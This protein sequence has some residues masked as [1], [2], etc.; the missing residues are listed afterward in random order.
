MAMRM[1]VLWLLA[2]SIST[3][4]VAEEL[5]AEQSLDAA[6]II[7]KNVAARGGLE[8]WRK[9]QTMVW[10][11][12]I[13]RVNAGASGMP[14]VL[15]QKRPNK[16]RFEIKAQDRMSMRI[17]DGNRGWKLRPVNNGMP[18]FQPFTADELRFARDGQGIEG[19]LMDYQA[20]GIVATL[21]GTDEVEGHKAYRLNIKL[22]S[23]ASHHVWIDAQTFLEVKYDRQSR[24]ALGRAGT[25]TVFYRNYQTIDGL[26]IPLVIESGAGPGQV[27]DKMVID[28]VLLNPPLEDQLFTNP[29]PPVRRNGFPVKADSS[30]LARSNSSMRSG[31]PGV[32][33]GLMPNLGNAH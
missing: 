3:I 16:T 22:P 5:V 17:Y 12:H 7:E 2:G 9:V 15:Q 1:I 30:P 25:V 32:N 19:P 29:G 26:Q 28:K 33:P 18:E 4:S 20:K 11:G 14:F 21:D 8:A 27:T 13:D 6:Q 31:F 24:N 23:G 10:L